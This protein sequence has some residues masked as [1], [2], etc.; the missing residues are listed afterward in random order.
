MADEINSL[1][2][3]FFEKVFFASSEKEGAIMTSINW[4]LII[5]SAKSLS[6]C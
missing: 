3:G 2:F 5:Y 4:L 1:I 6:T